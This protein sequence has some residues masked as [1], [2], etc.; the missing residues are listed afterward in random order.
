MTDTRARIEEI[1]RKHSG[2]GDDY[3]ITDD[4]QFRRDLGLDSLDVVEVAML[5]EDE[6]SL[7]ADALDKPDLDTVGALGEHIELLLA[8]RG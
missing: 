4:T 2:V 6:F 5:I 8:D 7:P 3:R 1:V